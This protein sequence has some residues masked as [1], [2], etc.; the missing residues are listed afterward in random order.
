MQTK[1]ERGGE[2]KGK[3]EFRLEGSSGHI[4]RWVFSLW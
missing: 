1:R 4:L 2:E 3:V